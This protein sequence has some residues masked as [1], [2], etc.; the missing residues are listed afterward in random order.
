MSNFCGSDLPTNNWWTNISNL[1]PNTD[2]EGDGDECTY[3][4]FAVYS[5]S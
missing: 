4:Y 1:F 2:S 3:W 5:V